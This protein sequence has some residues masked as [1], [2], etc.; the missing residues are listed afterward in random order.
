MDF[1]FPAQIAYAAAVSITFPL[2]LL[3]VTRLASLRSR[4]AVQFLVAALLQVLVWILGSFSLPDSYRPVRPMDWMLAGM[5]VSCALLFYLEV[6]AL[7][8]RGYTLS[9]LLTL[10]RAGRP[11]SAEEIARQYR[12]GTG[13]DWIMRHRV[14]GL[15]ATGLV[16]TEGGYLALIRPLGTLTAIAYRVAIAVFGFRRTG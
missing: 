12:G 10:L 14:G 9:M 4:N 16:R 6:W 2:L 7:M 8:S 13:L 15:E 3:L 5:V 11:L 1:R